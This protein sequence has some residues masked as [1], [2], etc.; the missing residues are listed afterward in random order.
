M[1]GLSIEDIEFI[2]QF[3]KGN[4]H[5]EAIGIFGSRA[6]GKFSKTS[7]LDLVFCGTELETVFLEEVRIKL[8]E[9]SPFPYFVDIIH[10]EAIVDSDLKCEIDRDVV[11]IYRKE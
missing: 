2:I 10:Y 4:A 8:D 6:T 3:A 1:Y 7:D 9:E 5:I 11:W